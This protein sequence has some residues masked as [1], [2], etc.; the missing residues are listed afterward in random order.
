MSSLVPILTQLFHF[1]SNHLR[2]LPDNCDLSGITPVTYGPS[3]STDTRIG[4]LRDLE[5]LQDTP[6]DEDVHYWTHG[7]DEED[8]TTVRAMLDAEE[9]AEDPSEAIKQCLHCGGAYV[10]E[11]LDD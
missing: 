4:A 3:P 6:T 9:W 7:D 2:S 8:K 1:L 11:I 5:P 10:E